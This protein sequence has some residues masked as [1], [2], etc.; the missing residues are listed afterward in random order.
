MRILLVCELGEGAL[1][2]CYARAFRNLDCEVAA[3]DPWAGELLR[4]R[5]TRRLMRRWDRHRAM[6]EVWQKALSFRP[7]LIL[8]LKGLGFRPAFLR[9][10]RKA[11]QALLFNFNPDN[12]FNAATGVGGPEIVEAVP[13][14]DCYFI[15]GR[16]LL[17][18]LNQAGARRAEYLP[19]GFDPEFHYPVALSEEDRALFEADVVFAGT[20]DREREEWLTPLADLKLAI[21]GNDWDRLPRRSPLRACWR[22]PAIY[23]EAVSRVWGAAAISLNLVRRQNGDAHNM[24][25]FEVPACGAFLL[26]TRTTEQR[27][28]LEEEREIACFST[29]SELHTQ[30]L[31]FRECPEVRREMAVAAWRRVQQHTYAARA[32]QICRVAVELG[33]SAP[34]AQE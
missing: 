3:F 30:V 21:W 13:E 26:T 11:T 8:I 25:T 1:G 5:W 7:D 20:W 28:F 16:F 15:W 34:V 14:Y 10:M 6:E 33:A 32:S 9:R 4:G 27:V 19:F 12:P 2:H 23:G 29:P 24:R 18:E 31:R 22:G 17:P